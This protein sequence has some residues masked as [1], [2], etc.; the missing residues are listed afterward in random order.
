MQESDKDKKM[1]T[2]LRQILTTCFI[3]LAVALAG[4][5]APVQKPD[6]VVSP[7]APPVVRPII[8]K[9]K[10]TVK[11]LAIIPLALSA[12]GTLRRE[13]KYSV[14]AAKAGK[15]RFTEVIVISGKE[16]NME[17]SRKELEKGKGD[18]VSS[19]QFKVPEGLPPGEY[20]LI[21]NFMFGKNSRKA[22]G[23]FRVK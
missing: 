1:K 9:D 23:R 18:H 15:I 10:I 7:S 16:I 11:K 13:L 19:F 17:L 21:T 5:P 20:Q 14:S 8:Q 22:T 4:C 6:P 2:S 12:G 3:M